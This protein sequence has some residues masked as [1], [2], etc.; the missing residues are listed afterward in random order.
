MSVMEVTGLWVKV[1]TLDAFKL[2]ADRG[3]HPIEAIDGSRHSIVKFD[4]GLELHVSYHDD[5]APEYRV[6][7]M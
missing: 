3:C 1:P 7:Q 5:W 4:D 6:R 2:I